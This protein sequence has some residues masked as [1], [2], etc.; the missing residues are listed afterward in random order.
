[1]RRMQLYVREY[2]TPDGPAVLVLHGVRNHGARFRRLADEALP[3]ARVIA[4]DL[5]GHGR[6][7]WEPP[8]NTRAHVADLIATLDGC[9]VHSP[10]EVIGHSFGGYLGCALAAAHPDRVAALVLLDPASGI[11]PSVSA[12]AAATDVRGEGRAATWDSF[13]DARDAWRA[14][15]PADGMWACD[16]D[17]NEFLVAAPDGG[18]RLNYGREAAITAWSEMTGLPVSLG[19]WRGPTTLVT[20]LRDPYVTARLRTQLREELG[21]QLTEVGIDS[22]HILMWDAPTET[23]EVVRAARARHIDARKLGQ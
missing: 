7:G 10:V 20:A 2:G 13:E 5:R 6:S 22:G 23:A 17:L 11:S 9:G 19:Q 1:M 8:W 16:E 18:Y 4:P 12:A 14:V 3:D 15:R 21:S